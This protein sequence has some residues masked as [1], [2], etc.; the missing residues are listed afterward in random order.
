MTTFTMTDN[1]LVQI[2]CSEDDAVRNL[3]LDEIC[4]DAPLQTLLDHCDALDL[5]WRNTDNL[6]HRVRA[7]FFLFSIHRFHLPT[8]FDESHSGNI[9]FSAFQH[10]LERRFVE[11]IDEL[12]DCQ[13]NSGACDGL[14][15]ALAKSYHELAFQTLADQV[16][17]SVRTVRG[18]QWMFRTGHPFDH[19]LRI[20]PELLKKDVQDVSYPMLKETTAVRMDFTHSAWSD[21]F[22]LGM[23]FPNG[24][25]VINASVNL[26]LMGRDEKPSPPIECFLRVI[27]QPMLKLTS[28]DLNASAEI[29]T[30]A[31]VFD[32]AKDYLGLLKAAVIAAG[33][34]P[35]GMEGSGQS[36]ESLL[37]RLVGPG[38]GLEIVS[39]VNNIPKG[40][41]LAVSTNLLGSL[42]SVC[43]RATGQVSDLTGGMKETDRRII[44]A[45]AILGEWIGGSG[46]GWQ[47]SGGVWPGIKLICGS[48]ATETDPEFGISRGRL[49][50]THTVFT[51]QEISPK[52]RQALQD[53]L[54][55]VHGGMAQNVG[56]ILEMVTEKYLLRSPIEWEARQEAIEILDEIT[57]GLVEGDIKAIGAATHRNFFGPLQK[58][59][60]WCTNLFTNSMVK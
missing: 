48:A 25:K 1:K 11:A 40:S 42:I 16:R 26:G 30:I 43:M 6:Y 53:S 9:P 33:I 29:H 21:I 7:L 41:R 36:I 27:D 13:E 20:R 56:P 10:L 45:R 37:R 55:L 17:K 23:D 54:V 51:E 5:F 57:R 46:G 28:T 18:N 15:S 34:V 31:E 8:R 60:P 47:D 39:K 3:S 24:A 14:S 12:L 4:Q 22:F 2:I 32:F 58:I 49:L 52:T 38:L 50:P 35:P 44:A 19:P 59:I